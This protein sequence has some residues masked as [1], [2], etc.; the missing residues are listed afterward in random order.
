MMLE[1]SQKQK[2]KKEVKWVAQIKMKTNHAHYRDD[3]TRHMTL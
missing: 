3:A 1:G 2:K